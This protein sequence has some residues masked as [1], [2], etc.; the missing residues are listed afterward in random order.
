MPTPRQTQKALAAEYFA[1]NDPLGWFDRLYQLANCDAGNISWADLQP[2]PNFVQWA[3]SHGLDG[4]HGARRAL[5]VGC[6]LGDDAEALA[7]IGFDVTAFDIS[8]A[9]VDWAKQRFTSTRVHYVAA[10]HLSPPADWHNKFDFVLESYTLQVLPQAFQPPALKQLA[11][12]VAPAG[13]LLLIA[14][15]RDDNAPITDL[16]WPLS[17]ADLK[18]LIEQGLQEIS[19]ED[20]M[21]TEDPPVRRF[22]VAY[23][24]KV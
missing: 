4:R 8:P 7:A 3:E 21:D 19:F 18:P 13:T 20:Y 16:P 11:A 1:R 24:R 10:D 22:R 12:F 6:G 2:N 23:Q 15:G 17:R 5:V 14:R 9:A